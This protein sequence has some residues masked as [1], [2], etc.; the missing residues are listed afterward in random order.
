VLAWER[1]GGGE[2]LLVAVNF[3]AAPC[4]LPFAGRLLLSTDP[5]RAAAGELAGH[6]GVILRA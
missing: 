5:G 6:E 2:R 1:A 3:G 4:P